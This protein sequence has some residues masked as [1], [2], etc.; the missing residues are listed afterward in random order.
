MRR[1]F[2]ALTRWQIRRLFVK[3]LSPPRHRALLRELRGCA[4]CDAVFRQYH[5]A[6]AHLCSTQNGPSP[7]AAERMASVVFGAL[8]AAP[9]TGREGGGRWVLAPAVALAC[10]ASLLVAFV[11]LRSPSSHVALDRADQL[12]ARGGSST[13]AADVGFRVLRVGKTTDP[14]EDGQQLALADVVTFTYTSLRPEM[15]YLALFGIQ[16]GG[17]V[18]WYYPGYDDSRS[19]SIQTDRLDEPLGDGIRLSKRHSPG[20]LRV[21]AVFLPRAIEKAEIEEA[22]QRLAAQPST[23]SGLKPLPLEIRGAVVSS[24]CVEL[25]E[26][27]GGEGM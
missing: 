23:V 5:A 27:N 9:E 14:V 18:R 20:R 19:I 12:V 3:G 2:H 15:R 11:A 6:E 24:I 17:I 26:S 22:V 10:A 4:E 13:P 1:H 8:P 16:G 21:F 25:V 7:L